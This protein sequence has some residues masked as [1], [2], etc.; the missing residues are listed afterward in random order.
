MAEIQLN[1]PAQDSNPLTDEQIINGMME[2]A[3]FMP[4][5]IGQIG[6]IMNTRVDRKHGLIHFFGKSKACSFSLQHVEESLKKQMVM[7]QAI[8]EI[9]F[10]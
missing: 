9:K 8:K 6:Q 1:E 3:E 4:G 5:L 7:N 10:E 2:Q